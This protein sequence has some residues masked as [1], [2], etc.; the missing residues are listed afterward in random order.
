M[1]S[2]VNV[3]KK[4]HFVLYANIHCVHVL[5][6]RECC[7]LF[8]NCTSHYCMYFLKNENCFIASLCEDLTFEILTE[9]HC[10]YLSQL[11]PRCLA[12]SFFIFL[13]KYIFSH[14]LHQTLLMSIL[15]LIPHKLRLTTLFC[16]YLKILEKAVVTA[17]KRNYQSTAQA[18]KNYLLKRHIISTHQ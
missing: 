9:V 11:I 3:P 1:I 13:Q 5:V 18:V 6:F 15:I 4:Y 12:S 10:L 16:S 14:T 17:N 8:E 7:S 2:L